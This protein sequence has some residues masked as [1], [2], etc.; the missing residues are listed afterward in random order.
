M[1]AA[2][3]PRRGAPLEVVDVPSPTPAAG[4]VLLRVEACG[5]CH[6]DVGVQS[7]GRPGSAFP[8]IPGHEV[9]GR[10]T[11][12]GE[13][14][15]GWS[16]GDRAGVG[17]HGWHD[18]T[19]ATCR[20][21]DTFACPQ[22][23]ITGQAFDGG[24][25]EFM[26]APV[27]GLA[28]VPPELTSVEAAPMMCAGVTTYNALR[29]SDA[30]AGDVVA[31][32]G[33]GGLGHLAV[34]YAAKM[35]FRTVAIGRGAEKASFAHRLGAAV[36]L[37]SAAQ[38]A[39][40]ELARLGGARVILTTATDAGAIASVLPGL[41]VHGTLLVV[42][43]PRDPVPVAVPLLLRGRASV[44]GWYSG[45]AA[46]SEDTLRFSVLTGVRPMTEVFALDA[47]PTAFERMLQG[48]VRFRAVL[49]P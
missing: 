6:S 27:E 15:T 48:S 39:G 12:V 8:R 11:E 32:L 40:A 9:I 33:I 13:R 5:V 26:V 7:G 4:E 36:Y 34:Q 24:Y 47:A 38:D 18:G 19:C 17:W 35:G 2:R 3:F 16:I 31:V 20:R 49:T 1:K 25:A 21:G 22:Q 23:K 14:V 41:A 30:R 45:V 42:G 10:I 43:V 28:A 46:D 29:H 37:D 44:A